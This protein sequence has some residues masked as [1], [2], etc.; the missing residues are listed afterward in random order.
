[1]RKDAGYKK[2]GER[3]K[4][5]YAWLTLCSIITIVAACD[6]RELTYYSEAEI[7]I[8]ADWTRAG[9]NEKE[10]QYGATALF[11]PTDGGSPVVALMGDRTHKTVHLKKGCYNVILFNRSFDDFDNIAFRGERNYHTLEAYAKNIETRNNSSSGKVITDSPDELA[12]CCI[13]G[14]EV[15][16]AMLGNYNTAS[17]APGKRNAADRENGKRLYMAPQKLTRK[18]TTK[19][20]I[21]GMNNI[22]HATCT[23]GGVSESIFLYSG[24]LSENMVTQ[25]FELSTP[26]KD[27]DSETNGTLSA[28]FSVFGFSDDIPHELHLEALLVDGKTLFTE[29]FK[30]VQ[31]RQE[32]EGDGTMSIVIDTACENP[33]PDVKEE[34][35][36]GFDAEVDNWGKEEN[37]DIDI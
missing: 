7:E 11:Y 21:K 29:S 25:E 10:Q 26:I 13:E 5:K 14:F 22:H 9:L 35:G 15:T 32:Q 28:T 8:T 33:V 23:L 2:T 6:R 36:S 20:H 34:G 18:I 27:P 37:S 31:I 16:S 17:T 12:A 4:R 3:F 30:D 19:I 1:M 24:K